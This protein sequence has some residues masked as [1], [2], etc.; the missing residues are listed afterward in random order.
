V[1]PGSADTWR[2]Q[3]RQGYTAEQMEALLQEA[4]FVDVE[5]RPTYRSLVAAAQEIRDRIKDRGLLIRLLAFPF[6]AAAVRLERWGL[7]FGRP[8]ALIA[9]GVARGVS[10]S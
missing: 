8:N 3:V 2:E 1:L 10:A 6:L 9:T 4:G 5:V 7:T